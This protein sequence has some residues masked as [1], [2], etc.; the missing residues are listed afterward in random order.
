[1]L[2]LKEA[3]L[4]GPSVKWAA[5]GLV[6]LPAG[7]LDIILLVAPLT[8]VDA[9]VSRI[10]ILSGVLGG[11]LVSIPVK[12]SG[13]FADPKITPLPPSA[14]GKGLLNVVTRTLRLPMKVIQPLLS[15][16]PKR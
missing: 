16:E 14:V 12:V 5:E 3:T 1:M 4:D 6:D 10:P 7:S 9:V 15:D 2:L 8:T 11:S 13:D